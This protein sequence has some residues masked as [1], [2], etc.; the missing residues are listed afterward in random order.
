MSLDYMITGT[1]R[2]MTGWLA[3][4]MSGDG[5]TCRHEWLAEFVTEDDIGK[6]RVPGMISGISDTCGFLFPGIAS[7]VVVISR[8]LLDVHNSLRRRFGVDVDLSIFADAL[9]STEG[10]RICFDDLKRRDV[11]AKIWDYCTDGLP[12]P[13]Y[14]W[15]VLKDLRVDTLRDSL[16]HDCGP[17][18]RQRMMEWQQQQQQRRQQVQTS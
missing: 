10:L 18:V 1:P 8:P 6:A 9:G 2:S 13:E 17:L 5:S 12:F 16:A 3:A 4:F 14:R 7:R 15:N 11:I